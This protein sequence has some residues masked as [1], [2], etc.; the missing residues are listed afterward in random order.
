MERPWRTLYL[1]PHRRLRAGLGRATTGLGL[2]SG[3]G[4]K[5][6]HVRLDLRH[7]LQFDLRLMVSEVRRG[8]CM[9]MRAGRQGLQQL[10]V[11]LDMLRVI[12]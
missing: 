10:H 11:D 1:P 3:V 2:P 6:L 4:L 5:L 7:A 12:I 9:R 8:V